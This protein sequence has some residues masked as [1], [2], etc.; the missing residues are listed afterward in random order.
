MLNIGEKLSDEEQAIA[1][2]AS[3][4]QSDRSSVGSLSIGKNTIKLDDVTTIPQEDRRINRDDHTND[5]GRILTV[6]SSQR[7]RKNS[8]RRGGQ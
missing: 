2:L 1:L 4:P 3:L 5:G 7:G 8:R 6:K